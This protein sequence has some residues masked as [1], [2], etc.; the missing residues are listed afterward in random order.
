MTAFIEG[1]REFLWF[2]S[3][4]L[5][6]DSLLRLCGFLTAIGCVV[7]VIGCVAAVLYIIVMMVK[8]EVIL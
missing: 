5:Q 6:S 8:K 3:W 1:F 2:A 7:V 4:L